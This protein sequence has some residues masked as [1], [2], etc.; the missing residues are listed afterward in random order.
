MR[1]PEFITK[2]YLAENVDPAELYDEWPDIFVWPNL[3][4][5]REFIKDSPGTRLIRF[6]RDPDW[7]QPRS[8]KR[9][10]K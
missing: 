10:A 8:A 7:R 5:A 1:R 2:L 4:E 6:V 9:G 3:R